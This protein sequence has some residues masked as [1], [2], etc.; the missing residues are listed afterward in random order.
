LGVDLDA[1]VGGEGL[2]EEAAVGRKGV[3]VGVTEVRQEAGV[4]P[5]MSVKTRVTVPVG[6]FAMRDPRPDEW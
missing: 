1:C 6:R 3:F 4:E 5:S 2:S